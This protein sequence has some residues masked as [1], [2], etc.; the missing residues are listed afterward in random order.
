MRPRLLMTAS[1]TAAALA[2]PLGVEA[3]YFT[4]PGP[5]APERAFAV[6]ANG[7]NVVTTCPSASIRTPR[8]C[9][10]DGTYYNE[11]GDGGRSLQIVEDEFVSRHRDPAQIVT[12]GGAGTA[13]GNR[14]LI[15]DGYESARIP[16]GAGG[17]DRAELLIGDSEQAE[18]RVLQFGETR[19]LRFFVKIHPGFALKTDV[20]PPVLG[21]AGRDVLISQT[22]QSSSS[23]N[24]IRPSFGPA[25]SINAGTADDKDL[26]WNQTYVRLSFKYRND[27]DTSTLVCP[28]FI[29][30][31]RTFL[32]RDILR[33]TWV[34]F[35]V[36]LKPAYVPRWSNDASA[37][38][39]IMVWNIPVSTGLSVSQLV[40]A[41]AL[42]VKNKPEDDYHF[43]W[44][45][46]PEEA[47]DALHQEGLS[48]RFAI[49]VGFYRN[50]IDPADHPGAAN[51]PALLN[52]TIFMDSVKLTNSMGCMAGKSNICP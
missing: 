5:P 33:D 29:K 47:Y 34:G 26:T 8:I 11:Y 28:S 18:E 27:C 38:G 24:A 49:R 25:F 35:I 17:T 40:D 16:N 7:E 21:G 10:P 42:N 20:S 3:G 32:T 4:F 19:Y 9:P 22:W 48:D 14:M 44:G 51:E 36:M 1:L 50:E 41:D 31:G 30:A 13:H 37:R 43:Y 52:N 45:Y 2:S 46:R 6:V 39:A 23:G 12:A 15:F